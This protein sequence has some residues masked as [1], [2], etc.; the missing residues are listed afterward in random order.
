ML[1][2]RV[3]DLGRVN[4]VEIETE[5]T[6]LFYFH[7]NHNFINILFD[8]PTDSMASLVIMP[9]WVGS[10]CE[11][12]SF[13]FQ[14]KQK[15]SVDEPDDSGNTLIFSLLKGAAGPAQVSQSNNGDIISAY[16]IDGNDE[17]F[18]N[19]ARNIQA[20]AEQR[21]ESQ[22][23]I[24]DAALVDQSQKLLIKISSVVSQSLQDGDVVAAIAKI[25]DLLE[26]LAL[27][28]KTLTMDQ[29]YDNN[30][31]KLRRLTAAFFQSPTEE[32]PPKEWKTHERD[33]KVRYMLFEQPD[34]AAK[35]KQ[36]LGEGG[37]HCYGAPTKSGKEFVSVHLGK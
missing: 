23:V 15:E 34:A 9:I 19:F 17:L 11:S 21:A 30:E 24:S 8:N 28:F 12:L 26:E 6:T 18:S 31:T 36:A 37:L 29:R 22:E 3:T 2:S 27:Y 5:C 35:F 33:P 14:F 10:K 1:R 7:V 16:C 4:A 25:G 20:L 32:P 13:S